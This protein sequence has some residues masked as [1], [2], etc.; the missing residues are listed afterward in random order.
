MAN[1]PL[2]QTARQRKEAD[3]NRNKCVAHAHH[4]LYCNQAQP[5]MGKLSERVPS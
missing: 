1:E 5:F 4:F 3:Y 2:Y